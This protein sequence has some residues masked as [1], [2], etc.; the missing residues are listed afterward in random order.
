MRGAID[1]L[2]GVVLQNRLRTTGLVL[3]YLVF[4]GG[5]IGVPIR[6][7]GTAQQAL[8]SQIDAR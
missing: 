8:K 1:N 4:L 5:A 2:G 3:L 6:S 7:L